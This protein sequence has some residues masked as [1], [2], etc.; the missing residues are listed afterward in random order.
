MGPGLR[1]TE[2]FSGIFPGADLLAG[3]PC[4]GVE[5]DNTQVARARYGRRNAA[6]KLG[7]ERSSRR[8]LRYG[9]TG[10]FL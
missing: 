1:K 3:I 5:E 8:W 2:N 10:G 6:L 7:T 9:E 4:A